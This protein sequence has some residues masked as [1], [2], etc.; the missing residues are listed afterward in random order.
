MIVSK[1]SGSYLIANFIQ[2]VT[3][4]LNT[5]NPKNGC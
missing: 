1:I 3:I 2:F 4:D 5:Y